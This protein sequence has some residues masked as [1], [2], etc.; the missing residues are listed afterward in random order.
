MIEKTRSDSYRPAREFRTEYSG[1]LFDVH[2]HFVRPKNDPEG[3][4]DKVMKTMEKLGVK[5]MLVM[6]TPNEGRR[7][8]HEKEVLYRQHLATRSRGQIQVMGGGNYSFWLH[9]TYRDG[10]AEAD[11]Q[12]ILERLRHGIDSGRYLGLGEIGLHH[13]DKNGH[14]PVIIFPP[15]FTPFLKL[16]G[17]AAEKEVWLTLHAEP[18]TPEG[19][20]HEELIFGGNI[21]RLMRTPSATPRDNMRKANPY[22]A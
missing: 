10:Y 22:G 13:F 15:N 3:Y 6:A 9:R 20:S 2:A 14:Q 11:L 17:I 1:P 21:L 5:R 19:K 8:N 4:M 7:K 18:L 12:S 16:A